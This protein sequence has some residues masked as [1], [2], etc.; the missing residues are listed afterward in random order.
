MP[1]DVPD[2]ANSTSCTASALPASTTS[3]VAARESARRSARRRRCGRRPDRRRRRCGRRPSS[4]R[5]SSRRCAATLPSTRRSDDTSLLMNA[6]PRRSRSRNSGVTRMP[7]WPQTTDSPAF[8]SRSLR[9]AGRPSGD[10]DHRVHPLLLDLHPPSA[11]AHV[12]AVVGG[13][14]E[15]VRHAAVLLGR[16]DERVALA[17]RVA[18]PRWSAAAAAHRARCPSAAVIRISMREASSLVRPMSNFRISYWA[19]IFDDLVEDCRQMAG[20]DQVSF[21]LYRVAGRHGCPF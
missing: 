13:R 11:H 7:S 16:L 10:D 1:S 5:A 19:L 21:G 2:S 3:H 17:H 9:Q 6:K 15:V 12:R 14:V 8:T 4:P 20:V 18:A